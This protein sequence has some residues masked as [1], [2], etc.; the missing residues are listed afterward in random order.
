MRRFALPV[1]LIS[2]LLVTVSCHRNSIKELHPDDCFTTSVNEKEY[3]IRLDT[4][5]KSE[6]CGAYFSTDS[7]F[8]TPQPFR[9]TL[10]R[11]Y[12][13]LTTPS[14][15]QPIKLQWEEQD[16]QM[17]VSCK[18]ELFPESLSLKRC[19][20]NDS[21]SYKRQLIEETYTVKDTQNVEYAQANGYWTSDPDKNLPF[22]QVY[23]PHLPDLLQMPLQPLYMDIYEPVDSSTAA[24]PLIMMIHGGAFIYGDKQDLPYKKWCQHFAS[25]GYVV[26]SINYR[27]G[28]LLDKQDMDCAGYRAVQ[29]ANAALRFL[30]A[31]A[32]KYRID[33][34]QIFTW[35][36]SAGGITALNVAFMNNTNRPETVVGEGSINGISLDNKTKFHVKAVANLWGAVH[37]TTILATSNTAVISIHGNADEIVPFGYGYPFKEMINSLLVG[38]A[39]NTISKF[40]KSVTKNNSFIDKAVDFVQDKVQVT[41]A[42][43]EKVNKWR[44]NLSNAS[45]KNLVS[46][47]YGSE[48]IHKYLKH[49]NRRSTL[50]K[51]NGGG[52]SLHVNEFGQITDYFY[53]IQ[54]SVARF[55]YTEIF[56]HPAFL[57]HGQTNDI[58]FT[59]DNQEIKEIHWAVEGGVLLST[60]DSSARI[61]FFSDKP[62]HS[63]RVT[64]KYKNDVEFADEWKENG[65][66][67]R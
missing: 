33:P 66:T 30:V 32:S 39:K 6:I 50:I 16:G 5:S 14:I 11:R 31:N 10:G 52:H 43:K 58:L 7:L 47:M 57:K 18:S 29:D 24:R 26:A 62:K 15:P 3:V 27:L 12:G 21:A 19:L 45:W 56:P 44:N 40:Y 38:T 65:E 22:S 41:N 61:L 34:N 67:P 55:F 13:E 49:H 42:I 28:C 64:G 25:L 4:V 2:L 17:N 51:V 1:L 63:V 53:T 48:C 60:T 20:P 8:A 9:V 23:L 35:G 37:D 59:I 54:D 46:P 36:S